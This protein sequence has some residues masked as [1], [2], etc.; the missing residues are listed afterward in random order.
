MTAAPRIRVAIAD[1][2]T[3]FCSGIQMLI[4]SQPD[5]LFVGSAPDGLAAVE[6]AAQQRPHVILMDI[7]MP[8]ID[9]LTATERIVGEHCDTVPRVIVLTTFQRDVAIL[10]AVAAG[11]SGFIMK[12]AT[13]EFLLAAIRTVHS[14]RSVI[15]PEETT[16]LIESLAE[17]RMGPADDA[18]IAA[19][20]PREKEVFLLAARGLTNAEIASAAYISET[21]VKSHVSSILGKLKMQSR[22]QLVVY[23]Y[24][25]GLLS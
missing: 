13:P 18:S 14:G 17:K 23:A 10:R 6:L 25:N 4:E 7:R 9:G 3:L 5:L 12:D 1:D 16:A 21:T 19:L 20:S 15:A 8:G 11:A 2:Q 24:E 22:L